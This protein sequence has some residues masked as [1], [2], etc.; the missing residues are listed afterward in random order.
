MKG[1][2]RLSSLKEKG[3]ISPAEPGTRLILFWSTT[4]IMM[5][6]NNN[7]DDDDNNDDDHDGDED[8]DV[9]I[10]GSVVW[11]MIK[12]VLVILRFMRSLKG[13]NAAQLYCRWPIIHA[14]IL[15]LVLPFYIPC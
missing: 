1:N 13:S 14:F 9:M 2:L 3:D 11:W 8:D 15:N 6:K 4:T 10:D 12:T 5:T 7:Y